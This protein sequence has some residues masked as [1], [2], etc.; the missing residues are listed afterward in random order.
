MRKFG[1]AFSQ[2]CQF[3]YLKPLESL[4]YNLE[5]FLT[6]LIE[7][8]DILQTPNHLRKLTTKNDMPSLL[9]NQHAN[10]LVLHC[11]TNRMPLRYFMGGALEGTSEGIFRRMIKVTSQACKPPLDSRHRFYF[12]YTIKEV[13]T[14]EASQKSDLVSIDC[15][16]KIRESA[17]EGHIQNKT[18][19]SSVFSDSAKAEVSSIDFFR[20]N[21]AECHY[22]VS[23]K[24]KPISN[25]HSIESGPS[26]ST[27]KSVQ[28]L[29]MSKVREEEEVY[30]RGLLEDSLQKLSNN[31]EDSKIKVS[32]F[33]NAFPWHFVCDREMKLIQLGTALMQVSSLFFLPFRYFLTK[34]R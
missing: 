32:S 24:S 18:L 17:S 30:A 14:A 12:K 23:E 16:R 2:E 1:K 10:Q 28:K 26:T 27:C 20:N 3:L 29:S 25:T 19:S 22:E 8:Y 31:V 9:C 21:R 6:N 15:G 7:V 33:C 34:Q 5:G 11:H 4:G 13:G